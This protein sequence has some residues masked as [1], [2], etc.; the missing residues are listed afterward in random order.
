MMMTASQDPPLDLLAAVLP[1]EL[2]FRVAS[3]ILKLARVLFQRGVVGA[4]SLQSAL[5]LA[6]RLSRA[7]MSSWRVRR[8][9]R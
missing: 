4:S 7:G 9:Y 3:Q 8:R 5:R 1:P 6:N 2:Y